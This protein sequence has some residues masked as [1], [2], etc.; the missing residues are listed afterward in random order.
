MCKVYNSFHMAIV[1]L[2]SETQA[3]PKGEKVAEDNSY[4]SKALI[5]N[6]SRIEP[7]L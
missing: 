1:C 2:L 3:S 4:C 6:H 7:D 5:C